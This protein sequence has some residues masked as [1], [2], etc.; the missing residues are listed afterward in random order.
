MLEPRKTRG[1][2]DYRPFILIFMLTSFMLTTGQHSE[3]SLI[4]DQSYLVSPTP[5]LPVLGAD[6]IL[7]SKRNPF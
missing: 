1:R 5:T 2:T 4:S 6:V 7:V 3:A